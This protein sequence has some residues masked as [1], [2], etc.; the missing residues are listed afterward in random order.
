MLFRARASLW[1]AASQQYSDE[2]QFSGKALSGTCNGRSAAISKQR[3]NDVPEFDVIQDI[4][5][6]PNFYLPTL[7][8][9]QEGSTHAPRLPM[10]SLPMT[11]RACRKASRASN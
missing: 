2:L 8:Q 6:A 7:I 5:V 3:P 11:W 1:T 10:A 9:V 4:Q